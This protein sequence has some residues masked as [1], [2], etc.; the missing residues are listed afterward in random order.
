MSVMAPS[1]QPG[2]ISQF[3]CGV[4]ATVLI[5]DRVTLLVGSGL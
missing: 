1:G 3:N 5:F 4:A 2:S